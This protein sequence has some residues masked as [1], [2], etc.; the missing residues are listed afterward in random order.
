[1]SKGKKA[2]VL[3]R[4]YFD[5]NVDLPLEKKIYINNDGTIACQT[6]EE[7]DVQYINFN[8]KDIKSIN[9]IQKKRMISGKNILK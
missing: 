3:E 9:I 6:K 1:M 5:A 7:F 2:V 8:D 4:K